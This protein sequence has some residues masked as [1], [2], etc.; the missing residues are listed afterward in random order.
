M[1]YEL[2]NDYQNTWFLSG[3]IV[4]SCLLHWFFSYFEKFD[5][6]KLNDTI[7][8]SIQT[9]EHHQIAVKAYPWKYR[10]DLSSSLSLLGHSRSAECSCFYSPQLRTYFDA[11]RQGLSEG[12]IVLLTHGHADHSGDIWRMNLE[13]NR[14][15]TIMVP[16]KI[17]T[18]IENYINS[19]YVLNNRHETD[20]L[21]KKYKIIGVEPY[22]MYDF[23]TS[24]N[25]NYAIEIFRCYHTDDSSIGYG[26]YERKKQIHDKYKGM[27]SKEIGQLVKE[28]KKNK[29]ANTPELEISVLKTI[30]VIA[31]IGDSNIRVLQDRKNRNI[32]KFPFIVIESTFFNDDSEENATKYKHIHWNHLRPY[33]INNPNN[34]FILIHFSTRHKDN[35]I[36][37]YFENDK[38]IHNYNNII[39][40]LG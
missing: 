32:F 23:T 2:F 20:A 26:I 8:S 12:D 29:T 9:E 22:Q 31:Y 5:D 36:M 6:A 34:T 7:D 28:Y 39:V 16:K 4:Y 10:R 3:L 27:T 19:A 40:W 14:V 38:K 21:T 15:M 30:P 24:N 11:G 25:K 13:F 18:Q 35:D 1:F 37:N 17:K 33:V